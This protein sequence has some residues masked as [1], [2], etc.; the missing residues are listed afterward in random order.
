M[1]TRTPVIAV[2]D[3]GKSNKKL[4]VFD[5]Q[6]KVVWEESTRF[7]EEA[8]DD[9]FPCENIEALTKWMLGQFEK[10]KISPDFNVKAV[11]FSTYGASLVHIDTNGDRVGYLYNYLKPYPEKLMQ[12]FIEKQGGAASFA[13]ATSSPVMGHLNAGM[14]LYWI[15]KEKT[16][17]FDRISASLHFPQYL[18]FL[19]TG[20]KMAEMTNVGCHSA[21]WDF[22]KM[23]YHP[24]VRQE[25][26]CCK[27]SPVI[28]GNTVTEVDKITVGTGLHDSSAATIPYLSCFKEPFI[29]LST[30]TWTISLNPFNDQLPDADELEKGCLSYLTYQGNPVKT[31]MLFAGNDHDRQV[32]RIAA[33]FN[34]HPDYFRTLPYEAPLIEKIARLDK[35]RGKSDRYAA[36]DSPTTPCAFH[37]RDLS[38][39]GSP[40]LAYH[41]LITDIIGQQYMSTAMVLKNSPVQNIYVDGGFCKNKIYMQLLANAFADKKVYSASMI[42]GTALGAALA[43]HT[44]WNSHPIPDDLMVLQ[45]WEPLMPDLLK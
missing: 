23:D 33:H 22:Q 15:K 8:D 45:Q 10:L 2:F 18:S 4:L 5:E 16:A 28:K 35:E 17:L 37:K 3:I 41:Q 19:I 39:F 9:G 24:W 36:L 20:K 40:G 12:E 21:L 34:V 42:Q 27:L 44:H 26:V 14:Q 43:L 38:I 32:T 11:N 13:T 7:E 29:I 25:G 1:K 6:Y 31:S 30:G